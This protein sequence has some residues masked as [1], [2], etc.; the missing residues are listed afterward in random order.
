MQMKIDKKITLKTIDHAMVNQWLKPKG[1]ELAVVC[2]SD[3]VNKLALNL[4]LGSFKEF[5]RFLLNQFDY[6][7]EIVDCTAIVISLEKNGTTWHFMNIQSNEW[8]PDDYGT[9]AHE[10]HHFIHF[11]FT[12]KGNKY[13][14]DAE[15]AYAYATGYFMTNIVRA[16]MLHKQTVKKSLKT[17]K[18]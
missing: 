5:K 1:F 3:P 15:E 2:I 12:E 6:K 14:P 16:F 8:C 7:A 11:G 9:I 17:K 18:K 10:L 4:V 13:C